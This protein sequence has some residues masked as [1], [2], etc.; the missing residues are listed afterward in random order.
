MYNDDYKFTVYTRREVE[1][2]DMFVPRALGLWLVL[3]VEKYQDIVEITYLSCER[4]NDENRKRAFGNPERLF[5][6]TQGY[7]GENIDR[8]IKLHDAVL[9]PRESHDKINKNRY[10]DQLCLRGRDIL[11]AIHA[12]I[13]DDSSWHDVQDR[14]DRR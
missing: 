1:P 10:R 5:I 4:L 7:A 2:G 14:R 6:T 13:L 9:R 8:L 3:A 11:E 12:Q